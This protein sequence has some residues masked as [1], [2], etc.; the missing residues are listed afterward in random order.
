MQCIIKTMNKIFSKKIPVMFLLFAII[1][2]FFF[3]AFT[4]MPPANN[5]AHNMPTD[6][7]TPVAH[8]LHLKGLSTAT[9]VKNFSVLNV[10]LLAVFFIVLAISYKLGSLLKSTPAL[11]I[12]YLWQKFY[13]PFCIIKLT[14]CRWLSLFELSPNSLMPA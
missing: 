1:G 4:V 7:K 8:F 3:C 12:K 2:V 11:L 14:I 5:G 6:Q 10:F 13:E 9:I